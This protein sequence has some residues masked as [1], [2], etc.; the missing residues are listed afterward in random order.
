MAKIS[1]NNIG[2]R[3]RVVEAF[4]ARCL[5]GAES[6]QCGKRWSLVKLPIEVCVLSGS[7]IERWTRISHDKRIEYQFPPWRVNGAKEREPVANV[8]T[9]TSKFTGK[10]VG[11]HRKQATTLA[12]RIIRGLAQ[13]IIAGK[14]EV[15]IQPT[16][17]ANEHLVLMK[18]TAGFV[19]IDI[20]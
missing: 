12:V 6:I 8:E 3:I 10:I 4:A 13:Y 11:I 20:D 2:T 5:V 15:R 18:L 14:R 17:E 1:W 9:T 19:L 7:D 16:V